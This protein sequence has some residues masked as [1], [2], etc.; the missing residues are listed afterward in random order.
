M[1]INHLQVAYSRQKAYAD[2]KRRH[3]EFE[4]GEKVYLKISPM[5]GLVRFCKKVK[6]IPHLGVPIK[7]FKGLV[8]LPMK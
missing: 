6:L 5:K 8:R 1:L 4:K 3:L 7:Y 2:H